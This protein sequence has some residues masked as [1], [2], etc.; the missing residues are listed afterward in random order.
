MRCSITSD[1]GVGKT[2][3]QVCLYLDLYP[4]NPSQPA[5]QGSDWRAW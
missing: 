3:R 1:V 5:H 2:G 4:T